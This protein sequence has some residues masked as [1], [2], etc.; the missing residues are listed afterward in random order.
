MPGYRPSW[1]TEVFTV[2]GLTSRIRQ[3]IAPQFRDILIEGEV[4]NPKLYPSGHLYFTLKDG[5][6]TIRS[7][8]FNA[9]AALANRPLADGAF[10]LCH[11]RVDVYEKRGEYQ[12]IVDA[13]EPKG[14]GLLQIRFEQLKQ[15]LFLEG[16][17]DAERKKP[18]PFFPSRIGIVTSPVG[19]AVRDM[20]KVLDRKFST[21][22]V[23]I[24]PV[25][26]QGEEAPADIIEALRYL[27]GEASE[28]V[29]IVARGGGAPEDLAPFNDEGV[30]RAIAA[31]KIP[32][33]SG[34][35]HEIDYTIADFVADAR[36]PTPTAAAELVVR[37]KADLLSMINDLGARLRRRM[38]AVMEK[39][40]L[41]LYQHVLGLR[42]RKDLFASY[43]LYVDDLLSRLMSAMALYRLAQAKELH[44]L[45]QR[46]DDLNPANVLRRGYSI[47]TRAGTG[48][49]VTDEALVAP[50]DDLRLTLY[51][52]VLGVTVTARGGAGRGRRGSS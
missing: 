32:V 4:S 43:R 25:K 26:V 51:R 22:R 41:S 45:R 49:V 33:V 48:E 30:A 47:T 28:D 50:G 14:M 29:I 8:M 13:V 19:A 18:L 11:G 38:D 52:G 6:A 24:Y 7:V 39:A 10:V 21:L 35:G 31:S 5:E 3:A 12:L 37:D 27:N 46:L 1:L 44:R 34:V 2:S 17:F 36:A 40:R 16:L 15:R 20:L 42:E 9:S 23:T